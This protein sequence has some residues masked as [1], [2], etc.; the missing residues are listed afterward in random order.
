MNSEAVLDSPTMPPAAAARAQR[1]RAVAQCT[2][3]LA[4]LALLIFAGWAVRKG[5]YYSSGK[6]L[7]YALGLIGGTMMLGLLFY[8]L[9]KR[10][11]FMHEWGPLK[12]WFQFH[13][14]GGILG[15][16]L[17]LFHSNFRVGSFNAAVALSCM[18]LVVASGLI[19]RFIYRKIHNGLYGSHAT[20]KE[21]EQALAKEFE[22]LAPVLSR[23]PLIKQEV[24]R[25]AALVSHRPEERGAR[26]VHFLSL[27]A[28]R[29]IA[30]R[31]LRR[32]LDAYAAANTDRLVASHDNLN[33][34]LHTINGTL[35]AAQRRAQ[36]STYERLFSL[37][38]VIHIPFLCMLV[39]TAI[40]HVVAVHVY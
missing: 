36:F 31:N 28:K 32:T 37:W 33:T 40:V 22:A 35:Q 27:G 14:A 18:L 13:M 6:G 4:L 12:Y 17:V 26:A 34:L 23:M 25:F 9:R 2:V 1:L 11:R 3:A 39:I 8:P 21:M 7:G 19:G 24:E 38:H 15:P 29:L 10:L 20:L 16:L 30:A 5:A